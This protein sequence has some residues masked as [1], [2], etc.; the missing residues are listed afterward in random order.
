MATVRELSDPYANFMLNP[1][2]PTAPD[3]CSVCLTFTDGWGTCYPCGHQS[4]FADA[5]LP[6]SYSVAFGQLHTAL[7]QYKRG[8]QFAARQ[9]QV[10]LAA[11]LWRF[12]SLHEG[13]LARYAGVGAFDLVTTVPSSSA[14]R[15]EAHPLRR[16]IA[17]VISPTR[18]R[19]RR[20]LVRSGTQVAERAVD[21]GKF[22]PT[23]DLDGESILLVDDTWTTGA[24]VQ[25]AA[26]ALKTAGSGAVGVLVVGRHV[27]NDFGDNAQR[28]RALPRP[29]E[30][31]R[32][33]VDQ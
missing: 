16:L 24:S 23:A 14:E 1:L 8:H 25:S 6:I 17:D 30:W 28:L 19:H 33:A 15:D 12:V 18:T 27:T 7:Q 9:F 22:S 11:L 32:C 2:P 4:R 5:V 13:C 10:Q 3:V 31:E 20:L 26:A 29:F 21:P